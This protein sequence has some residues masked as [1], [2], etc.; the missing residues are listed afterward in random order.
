MANVNNPHKKFQWSIAILGMNP[1]LAQKVMLPERSLDVIEHGEGNHV[2][3]TAGMVKL[4][5]LT[6]EKLSPATLPDK[7]M[8]A[9]IAS[10]QNEFV[11]GGLIP[12]AYKKGVQISKYSTDGLTIVETWNWTGVFPSKINGLELDRL[13]S[14]N[15]IDT[16]EFSVDREARI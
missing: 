6:I 10:I 11:G 1:F 12:E 2:I 8:W 4:G 7:L 3:K 14:D 15:T 13:S 5:T 16:I 9:W